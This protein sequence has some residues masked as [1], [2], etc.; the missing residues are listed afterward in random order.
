MDW[1]ELQ[2]SEWI[3]NYDFLHQYSLAQ[4]VQRVSQNWTAALR[5]EFDRLSAAGTAW[6]ARAQGRAARTPPWLPVPFVVPIIALLCWRS[7]R[8][9]DRLALAWRLR[10][11]NGPLSPHTA[12]LFYF[13]TLRLLERRGWRKQPCQTPLEFAASLP[14]G[15]LSEPVAQLT[16]IYQSSRFGGRGADAGRVTALL[17][18]LEEALRAA[19]AK[20]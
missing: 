13:R 7:A 11:R 10:A 5:A 12:A 1:F 16:E 18:R 4:G 3:I 15:G 17:T 2:W 14:P 19:P 20:S 6:M 9:R 8:L